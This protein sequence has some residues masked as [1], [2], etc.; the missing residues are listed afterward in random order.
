MSE[1]GSPVPIR[2][3]PGDLAEHET[4]ATVEIRCKNEPCSEMVI[5]RL[6]GRM[7]KSPGQYAKEGRGQKLTQLK[8][9]LGEILPC[10]KGPYDDS[11]PPVNRST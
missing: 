6:Q 9:A 1:T 8:E 3:D 11:I 5:G 7:G 2:S 10:I 4:Q